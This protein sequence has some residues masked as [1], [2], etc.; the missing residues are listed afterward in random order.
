[1]QGSEAFGAPVPRLRLNLLAAAARGLQHSL[2][3]LALLPQPGRC[4]MQGP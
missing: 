4:L 1:M 3:L 2:R